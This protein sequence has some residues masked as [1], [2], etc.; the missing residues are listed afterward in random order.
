MRPPGR[1]SSCR[2]KLDQHHEHEW[3]D[4]RRRGLGW[5]G[6]GQGGMGAGAQGGR[7]AGGYGGRG[8]G[9][10]EAKTLNPKPC[11][12]GGLLS[13]W[14]GAWGA[15]LAIIAGSMGKPYLQTQSGNA[16]LLERSYSLVSSR[17]GATSRPPRD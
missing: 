8:S 7:E 15:V 3:A 10:K 12:P 16:P 6:V 11:S 14:L 4:M 5:E 13:D 1:E 17:L 9:G 2:K